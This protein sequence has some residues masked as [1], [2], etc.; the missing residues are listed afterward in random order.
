MNGHASA[1]FPHHLAELERSGIKY[2]TAVANSIYS[3]GNTRELARLLNRKNYSAKCGSGLVFPYRGP[4]GSIE[5]YRVKPVRPPMMGGK[6]VKYLSPVGA[7]PRAYFPA[8]VREAIAGGSVEIIITEGEKKSIAATQA[9]F[10]C[11]GLP[12]VSTWHPPKSTV[13]LPELSA[14]NWMGRTAFIIFDSD[15]SENANVREQV[16]QLAAALQRCGAV[17]KAVWLP[18][19]PDGAKMGLDDYLLAHGSGTLRKLMD[20]AEAPEAPDPATMKLSAGEVDPADVA[21]RYDAKLASR[22]KFY[23][24]EFYYHVDGGY[25]PVAYEDIRARLVDY[26]AG[27]FNHVRRDHVGNVLEHF[28]ARTLIPSHLEMPCWLEPSKGDWPAIECV[29]MKN[30]VVHLPSLASGGEYLRPATPRFFTTAS[31]GYAFDATPEPPAAWLEFL[32]SLWGD[33]EQSIQTLQ[34]FMGYCLTPDTRQQKLL[35]IVGP[36]RSGKGTILRVTRAMVGAGN[37]AAPTLSSLAERFGCWSLIGKT[38]AIVSDA[39]LS[40]RADQAVITER[41]LSITGEDAQTIDRKNLQPITTKLSTRFIIVTNELPRLGDASG[42]LV[43]RMVLLR[44]P[45]SFYGRED[46]GLTDRLLG[47]LPGIFMWAALGWESLRRRGRFVQPDNAL[48]MLSELSDLSSPIS[49]FVR[50]RCE[51]DPELTVPVDGLYAAW[52][53]WCEASG[54][55][56]VSDKATFGRDLSACVPSLHRGRRRNGEDGERVPTYFGIGLRVGF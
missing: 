26:M 32:H 51:I 53:S 9:G 24:G 55:V 2:E 27:E 7:T 5:Q 18:S 11:I 19:G 49:A 38:L 23:G 21:F 56:H 35:L 6:P 14:I 31:V 48:E 44:T 20:E 13:P 8:G 10:I 34:E 39:R 28:K 30:G 16:L 3:E 52:K 40:G 4:T 45:N 47:E 41:I 1:I 43:S 25:R 36:K 46:H 17:V 54:K 22:L 42:A 37:V 15:A 33:D 12:G 50:E 29:A